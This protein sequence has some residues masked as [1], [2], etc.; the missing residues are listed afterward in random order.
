MTEQTSPKLLEVKINKKFKSLNKQNHY[1]QVD[2]N[3]LY[4]LV[5]IQ[6]L[7]KEGFEKEV[8]YGGDTVVC[9]E[10]VDSSAKK[11]T[12][13]FYEDQFVKFIQ[14]PHSNLK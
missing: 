4:D 5:H 14:D 9:V 12:I 6:A 13:W 11:K 7:S 3:L 2:Y 10:Y 8:K 1:T